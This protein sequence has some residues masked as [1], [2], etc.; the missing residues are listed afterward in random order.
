MDFVIASG[1]RCGSQYVVC[2][3]D[4]HPAIRCYDE[5]FHN[6][7]VKQR[8]DTPLFHSRAA[9]HFYQRIPKWLRPLCKPS[10]LW[11]NY[12]PDS[13][14]QPLQNHAGLTG[15]KLIANGM[16]AAGFR[17]LAKNPQIKVVLLRRENIIKQALS[18]E[19]ARLSD[20]WASCQQ[21]HTGQTTI[22]INRLLNKIQSL[23]HHYQHCAGQ[24]KTTGHPY[25]ELSYESLCNQPQQIQ[26]QLSDF[27]RVPADGFDPS[28]IPLVKQTPQNLREVIANFSELEKALDAQGYGEMLRD[29]GV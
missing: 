7:G 11:R 6:H 2:L 1:P 4:S 9:Q 13:C 21:P 23:Q 19:L 16:Q 26:K 12:F 20:R 10:L 29:T 17:Y 24:I 5:L 18:H 14:L 28:A 25:I 15:F 22:D 27:L 8:F 3:L